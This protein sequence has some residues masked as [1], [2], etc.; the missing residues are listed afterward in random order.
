MR[1]E[2]FC[3]EFTEW[4]NKRKAPNLMPILFFEAIFA[5]RIE[6]KKISVKK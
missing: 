1:I 4:V 2:L 3:L 5:R 6:P